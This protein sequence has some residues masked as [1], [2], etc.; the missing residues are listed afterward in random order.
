MRYLVQG[1]ALFML[2]LAGF[3]ASCPVFF[4][5]EGIYRGI[6]NQ[7]K[8]GSTSFLPVVATIIA[9]PLLILFKS[10]PGL[11][12]AWMMKAAI[13]ILIL[14]LLLV[15]PMLLDLGWQKLKGK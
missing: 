12:P 13:V 11:F 10:L 8:E 14:D 9:L 3:A 15:V 1:I 7:P 6:T 2:L 5:L 4:I